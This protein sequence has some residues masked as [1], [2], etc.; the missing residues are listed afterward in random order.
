MN[1]NGKNVNNKN[2]PGTAS[3]TIFVGRS[4]KRESRT[5][6]FLDNNDLFNGIDKVFKAWESIAGGATAVCGGVYWVFRK[7]RASRT[8]EKRRLERLEILCKQMEIKI[9]EN[10]VNINGLSAIVSGMSDDVH[11]R[12]KAQKEDSDKRL[13]R[14]EQNFK[15]EFRDLRGDL[16][17]LAQGN[18]RYGHP[19]SR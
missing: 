17:E 5:M 11:D 8:V 18:R 4:S 12:I 16:F 14:L 3:M 6:S 10:N 9:G 13:D 7:W 1:F 15:E 19:D 2:V